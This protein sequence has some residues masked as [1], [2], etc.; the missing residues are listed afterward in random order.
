M[1][2]INQN[3]TNND[4][5]PAGGISTGIG[6]TISWQRGLINEEG[7]NG[8]FLLEVMESVEK[9]IAYYQDTDYACDENAT[10]LTYL[11]LAKDALLSRRQKRA[12]EGK[13]DTHKV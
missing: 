2:L 8:A 5:T 4:G 12:D 3:W 10:A 9:R 11:R 13:L 1:T 6:F 7:R